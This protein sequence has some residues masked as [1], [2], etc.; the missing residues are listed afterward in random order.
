MA[1]Q[2]I[3]LFEAEEE[4]V[5]DY[6][7]SES[8]KSTLAELRD[9]LG[10]LHGAQEALVEHKMTTLSYALPV[11]Y[12]LNEALE[13]LAKICAR[14]NNKVLEA[15]SKIKEYLDMSRKN[16]LHTLAMGMLLFYN[17]SSDPFLSIFSL[18]S[19]TLPSNSH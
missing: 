1:S 4:E 11:A 7:L 18:Q 19:S 5:A 12:L 9:I 13:S 16:D 14:L 6:A 2:A 17:R 10:V 15:H 8:D 3:E